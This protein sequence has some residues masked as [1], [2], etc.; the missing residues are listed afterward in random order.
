MGKLF[1]YLDKNGDGTLTIEE[2]TNGLSGAKGKTY[3]DI[4]QVI[5]KYYKINILLALIQ[6]VLG[7]LIILNF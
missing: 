2:I 4:K 6:M 5:M 7:K 1:R 3:D